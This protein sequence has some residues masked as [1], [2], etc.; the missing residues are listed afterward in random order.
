MARPKKGIPFFTDQ[1]VPDSVGNVLSTAGH[2][3]TR[4]RDVMETNTP[5]PL[6]FVACSRTGQVLVTHDTDFK[7][8]SKK[9]QI[10]QRQYHDSLHRIQLRCPEP[11][12][13]HRVTEALSLIEAEWRKVKKGRPMVIE[14]AAQNM[15]LW[16]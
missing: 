11:Q 6:I 12:S 13:A 15:K 16:R 10:T 8:L 7:Q 5:D 14:I 1:N 3:V 4:L 2:V 9:L